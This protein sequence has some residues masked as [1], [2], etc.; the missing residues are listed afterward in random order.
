MINNS[1]IKNTK[2]LILLTLLMVS[3][4]SLASGLLMKLLGVV[5]SKSL[6]EGQGLRP[7]IALIIVCLLNS[8]II[9]WYTK[10]STLCCNNLFFMVFIVSFGVMFFMTQIETMYFNYAIK[11]PRQIIFSTLATGV[12]VGIVASVF[13]VK[14]KKHNNRI[15]YIGAKNRIYKHKLRELIL[16]TAVLATIYTIF[17][18]V[19]GYYIAWQF[20]LLREY[21]TGTQQILPFFIHMKNQLS[22]DPWLVLF[23]IF[24][25]MLW[26]II[27]YLTAE[28]ISTKRHIEKYLLVA[29]VLSIGLCTPLLVPNSFMP[30]GVRVGHFFE[31]LLEN[32][33]FG[34]ILVY[35]YSVKRTAKRI[36]R[37][38]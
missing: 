36:I 38:I 25:G 17:Y 8:I 11:M 1:I 4:W 10:R 34:I 30:A 18:F 32:F 24:R 27:G 35:F 22:T 37:V 7:L 20:P 21:Y 26:A 23:Q 3:V 12:A 31:L 33:L 28:S 29:S 13:A 5:N 6:G 19:F 14:I 9:I 15:E 16:K 2:Y